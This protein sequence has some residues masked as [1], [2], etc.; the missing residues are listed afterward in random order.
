MHRKY[1]DLL[2]RITAK[3]RF[4]C[5][6]FFSYITPLPPNSLSSFLLSNS[7]ETSFLSLSLSSLSF[8]L[9]LKIMDVAHFL[10]GIFGG[11]LFILLTNSAFQ[12]SV[13]L[14][15]YLL[16]LS[17]FLFFWVQEMLLLY[18]FSWLQCMHF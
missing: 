12:S 11:F 8:F 2:F 17:A 3:K 7:K 6:S 10:F 16:I 5:D 9:P 4:P 14:Y 18:S 1:I 15:L 13:S